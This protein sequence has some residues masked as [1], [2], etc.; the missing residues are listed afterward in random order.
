MLSVLFTK[1]LSVAVSLHKQTAWLPWRGFCTPK[2]QYLVQT[3]AAEAAQGR[4]PFLLPPAFLGGT[5]QLDPRVGLT[6]AG[7]SPC[8]ERGTRLC[9]YIVIWSSEQPGRL[10]FC[11]R[12]ISRQSTSLNIVQLSLMHE[13]FFYR[14]TRNKSFWWLKSA[15]LSPSD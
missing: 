11:G 8:Q 6:R 2:F 12:A 10:S 3:L 7:P 14:A 4:L 9:L 5:S 13:F 1:K 15:A